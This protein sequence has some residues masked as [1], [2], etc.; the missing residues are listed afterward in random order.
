MTVATKPLLTNNYRQKI[1]I[2]F[3]L[4]SFK[5]GT[6]ILT[7]AILGAFSDEVKLLEDSLQNKQIVNLKGIRFLTGELRGLF[8]NFIIQFFVKIT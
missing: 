5:N 8:F 1:G 7:T 6:Q 4:F 2:F 3:F